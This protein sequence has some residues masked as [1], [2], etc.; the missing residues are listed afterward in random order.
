MATERVTQAPDGTRTVERSDNTYVE[1]R[2][3]GGSAGTI[4]LAFV[5]LAAVLIVGFFLLNANRQE[6]AR[7]E[8]ITGAA[9]SVASSAASVGD[10]VSGAADRAASAIPAP[11]EAA[12]AAE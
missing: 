10:S 8:A 12:P 2:S 1:R 7:T 9:D 4:I 3:G 11:S 5:A 6:T